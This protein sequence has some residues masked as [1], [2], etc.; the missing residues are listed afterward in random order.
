[1]DSFSPKKPPKIRRNSNIDLLDRIYN[2]GFTLETLPSVQRPAPTYP[3]HQPL[4]VRVAT[5]NQSLIPIIYQSQP[6]ILHKT[7]NAFFEKSQITSKSKKQF[8]GTSKKPVEVHSKKQGERHSRKELEAEETFENDTE[9]IIGPIKGLN[10]TSMRMLPPID[11]NLSSTANFFNGSQFLDTLRKNSPSFEIE[12][13][14]SRY[15]MDKL[16]GKL[17]MDKRY[18]NATKGRKLHSLAKEPILVQ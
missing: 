7:A 11:F 10:K 2:Q 9:E 14:Q 13:R 12:A 8:E 5:K 1:M 15:L 16:S 6:S 4:S 3:G 17:N 18:L